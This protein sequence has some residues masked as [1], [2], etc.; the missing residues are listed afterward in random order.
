MRALLGQQ[1]LTAVELVDAVQTVD[2]A[3]A[4]VVLV[5]TTCH[6]VAL[7]QEVVGRTRD[8]LTSFPDTVQ[9]ATLADAR[10]KELTL[11]YL[12]YNIKLLWYFSHHL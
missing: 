1:R 7:A 11:K 10:Q 5:Q 6:V 4:R 2:H 8:V 9:S 3:V 12:R